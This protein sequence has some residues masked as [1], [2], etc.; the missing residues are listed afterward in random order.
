MT[1]ETG[2]SPARLTWDSARFEDLYARN[3]APLYRFVFFRSGLNEATAAEICAEVFL[4]LWR[5]PPL[6]DDEVGAVLNGIARRKLADFY[7]SRQARREVR[8]SDLT[9]VERLRLRGLLSNEA[10]D[11]DRQEAALTE[12]LRALVG[13][14][15]SEL[16]WDAQELLLDKYVRGRSVRDLAERLKLSETAVMSA[17]ARALARLRKQLDTRIKMEGAL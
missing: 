17:L 13:E 11:A 1:A 4:A 15:L 16:D 12:S 6:P 3:A 10:R 9:E 5:M 7:R 8:F 2:S 14:A